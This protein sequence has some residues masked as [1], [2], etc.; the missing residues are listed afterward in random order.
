MTL[1]SKYSI[2]YNIFLPENWPL[3]GN[4]KKNLTSEKHG[5]KTFKVG[6]LIVRIFL[7][8]YRYYLNYFI[9]MS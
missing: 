4:L 9:I 5:R 1:Q 3:T 6:A 7:C 2:G 8:N